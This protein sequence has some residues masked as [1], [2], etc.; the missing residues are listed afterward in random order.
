MNSS[1]FGCER[2]TLCPYC[3]NL[4]NAVYFAARENI[5]KSADMFLFHFKQGSTQVIYAQILSP[6]FGL[7][8]PLRLCIS[9]AACVFGLYGPG[10]KGKT[11]KIR[12]DPVAVRG[13]LAKV[14]FQTVL[15]PL[16]AV[17]GKVLRS[18]ELKP[19]DLLVCICYNLTDDMI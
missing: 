6:L 2:L 1:I 19:E 4:K 3:D 11:V 15:T 18:D 17:P 10:L 16:G 7:W 5:P 12:C 13:S 14:W 8:R 9:S